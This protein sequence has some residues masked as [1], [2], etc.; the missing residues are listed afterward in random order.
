[1]RVRLRT[2]VRGR[3]GH[4]AFDWQPREPDAER[5]Q[6]YV[7]AGFWNDE[8]LGGILATGLRAVPDHAFTVR[9]ERFP[10]RGTF[11]AVDDRAGRVAAG[12]RARGIGPGDAVAFQLP[13]WVDAAATFY[14]IA[15]LGAIVVPIVHFYGAKEVAYI[16]RRTRVK[17]LV[18]ADRFGAQD[19]LA[20]LDGLR[21]D[22]PDLEW[23]A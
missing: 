8:S 23:A 20:N 5:A 7:R 13:N 1:M 2:I 19:F 15:Y 18:T 6:S 21:A 9:S 14:A 11:G 16:L 12:L 10:F 22:L 3:T 17:A 4:M